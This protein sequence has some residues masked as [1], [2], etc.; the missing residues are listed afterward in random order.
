MPVIFRKTQAQR[1]TS[2]PAAISRTH[3]AVI[4][5]AALCLL[6]ILSACADR[7][8]APNQSA[9]VDSLRAT[10]AALQTAVVTPTPSPPTPQPTE[11]GQQDIA[12]ASRAVVRILTEQS[13]GSGFFVSPNVLVTNR[14]VV[15]T[16]DAVTIEWQHG[17][18]SSASVYYVSPD[19]D[20][21]VVLSAE[22]SFE[23]LTWAEAGAVRLADEVYGIGYPLG[24]RGLPVVTRG[25]VSRYG[26]TSAGRI[27]Q[28]DAALNPGNSGGPLVD[29]CGRVVGIVTWKFTIAEG[30]AYA[31]A[32]ADARPRVEP[33]VEFVSGRARSPLF[34]DPFSF[35]RWVDTIDWPVHQQPLGIYYAGDP[36]P[37]GGQ[38]GEEVVWRCWAGKVLGCRV[39]ASAGPCMKANTSREP[40][41]E[42]LAWCRANPWTSPP[43]AVTGH[44]S[45]FRWECSGSNPI[46]AEQL[47]PDSSID[48]LGYFLGPWFEIRP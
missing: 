5:C 27:V 34:S 18:R 31:I 15:G 47:I 4:T 40:S 3:A 29:R 44:N 35:C 36:S 7:E 48:G 43:L 39:M 2:E 37:F 45:I 14:H 33:A 9:D 12:R 20:L 10:V 8:P 16:S 1:H 24:A 11:C 19:R 6:P 22:P 13:S 26:E 17:R 41:P 21:A 46:I 28:T 23:T 25:I 42:L 38:P 32:T 30:I